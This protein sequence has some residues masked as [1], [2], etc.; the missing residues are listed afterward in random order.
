MAGAVV[1]RY[2]G[3]RPEVDPRQTRDQNLPALQQHIEAMYR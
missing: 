2:T 1:L 3:A